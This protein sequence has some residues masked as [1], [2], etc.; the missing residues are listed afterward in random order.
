M[1]IPPPDSIATFFS[2]IDG[3]RPP[4]RADRAA[5]GTLPT[6]AFRYCH[7]VTSASGFGWYLYPPMSFSLLYNGHDLFWTYGDLE[8]WLPLSS[9]QYPY[10]SARFDE[11]APDHAKNCSP[12][13]LTA[14]Q[15]PGVVQ[16]WTGM[17][18]RTAPYWSLLM[19]APANLPRHPAFDVYDGI[20][21]T[22][23]WFGPLFTNIRICRTD[24]PI[25]FDA[26]RPML[27]AQPVPQTVYSEDVLGRVCVKQ[28]L[29]TLSDIEWAAYHET[30]VAPNR[31]ADRRPGAYAIEARRRGKCPYA[32][33]AA[34]RS[35]DV[36]MT[37]TEGVA[38]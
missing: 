34:R 4:Q 35:L 24:M 22:D 27:L 32:A 33:D 38:V 31:L 9:V 3:A 29:A 36:R 2:L 20:V 28:G 7:A 8:T 17:L 13:F 5:L 23:R 21:E 12:P 37:S 10:F 16:V 11:A 6:R 19:R 25:T 1:S 15:E 26:D 14:L 18:A 30:I